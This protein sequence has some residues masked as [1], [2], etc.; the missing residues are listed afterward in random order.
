MTAVRGGQSRSLIVVGPPGI[1]KSWLCRRACR[2]ADGFTVVGTRG[3][4]S[5]VQLGYGG[6]FDVLS[7]LLP[8]RLD[9]LLAPRGQALRGALKVTEAA[10]VDPFAVAVATLICSP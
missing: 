5:E 8:G 7:P 4:E 10:V 3:V 6:L 9:R 2:L 1:G